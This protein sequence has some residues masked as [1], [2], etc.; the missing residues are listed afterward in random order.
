MGVNA[1]KIERAIKKRRETDKSLPSWWILFFIYILIISSI[2]N[3][4]IFVTFIFY[5][6]III[7]FYYLRVNRVY[8][9][10]IRKNNYYNSIIKFTK[11]Y[12]EENHHLE[13]IK[14]DLE[15]IKD[16]INYKLNERTK[17]FAPYKN[18]A[19]MS[20]SFGIY[21]FWILYKLNKIWYELQLI[22][23]E[24][25]DSISEVWQKIGLIK[26]PLNF[27]SIIK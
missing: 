1:L 19:I 18:I 23:Q 7:I 13:E 8:R 16:E 26:Y 11:N 9:F 15:H 22:E 12:A 17:K 20:V 5:F 25:D 2:N 4:V 27:Y 21:G 14:K 3:G 6:I 10:I 24:F